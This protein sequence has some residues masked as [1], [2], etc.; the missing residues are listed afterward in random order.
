MTNPSKQRGTAW[1]SSCVKGLHVAGFVGAERRALA[2]TNDKG[3]I[4][5]VGGRYVFECKAA[6]KLELAEWLKETETERLNAKAEFGF[7]LIKLP[8]RREDDCPA[9]MPRWQLYALL[10]EVEELRSQ[11]PAMEQ[12]S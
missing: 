11:S 6:R 4:T 5:G 7:T 10:A 9:M 3:D 2:G 12:V 1:E 8:R